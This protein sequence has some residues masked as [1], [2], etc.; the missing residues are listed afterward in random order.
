MVGYPLFL[1]I[2]NKLWYRPD[3]EK[4]FK[5]EPTVTVMVVAH[6]EEKVI[7]KKLNNITLII[8]Q[9]RSIVNE[10]C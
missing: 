7:E 4:D 6:N 10:S 5:Y 1:F 9:I 2:I 8:A 3:L